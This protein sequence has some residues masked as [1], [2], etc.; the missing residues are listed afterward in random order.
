MEQ[1]I[2]IRYGE[3]FLKKGNRPLFVR[4]LRQALAD[5]LRRAEGLGNLKV[6]GFHGR[7]L[8]RAKE[9]EMTPAQMETALQA[10][11]RTFGIVSASPAVEV[12]SELEALSD[13]AFALADREIPASRAATFKVEANRAWKRF[14]MKSPDIGKEIGARIIATH[15]LP[16]R[17]KN[18]ELMVG[19]DIYEHASYVFV[20]SVPGPGGLPV[21]SSGRAV[22]LLSGGI[23]SPVAGWMMAKRGCRLV[24]AH[25]H[26]YP[27]TSKKALAKVASLAHTLSEWHGSLRLVS[28]SITAI[29]EYLR[30]NVPNDK[31]VLFYRRTMVRLAERVA[32]S[33]KARALITGESLGQVASQTMENIAVIQDAATL[34][35]LRPLI[36]MD[37]MEA[38]DLARRI[39]TYE[40][41]IVPH[42]D[43]CSLFLPPHP[44]TRGDLTFIRSVEERL[45]EL[46]RLEDEAF[47]ARE[48]TLVGHVE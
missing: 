14:P 36:G 40:T 46:A 5:C 4:V 35:V 7:F 2:L 28:I 17:M 21:G 34:P 44:E 13:A 26:S 10:V 38:V 11:S 23:D 15:P 20:R 22:L 48:E 32:H 25:F 33:Q 42:D 8:V 37:K 16:V 31:L 41:S 18:P 9:G 43:C 24:A 6:E 3:I 29:Q 45:E 19:I 39:G 1:V 27:Y 12:P 30:D 47:A